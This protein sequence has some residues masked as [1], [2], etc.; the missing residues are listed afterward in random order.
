MPLLLAALLALHDSSERIRVQGWTEIP[1][2][3]TDGYASALLGR[4]SGR[5]LIVPHISKNGG[6]ALNV[7]LSS[8]RPKLSLAGVGT[9]VDCRNKIQCTSLNH[10]GANRFSLSRQ[11]DVIVV[12]K[13]GS[14]NLTRVMESAASFAQLA[15]LVVIRDPVE[16]VLSEFLF[17]RARASSAFVKLPRA[18][19]APNVTWQEWVRHPSE[20]NFQLAF[21]RGFGMF[22]HVTTRSD[23]LSWLDCMARTPV[24]LVTM[25]AINSVVPGM[26]ARMLPGHV[27]TQTAPSG[28]WGQGFGQRGANT[29]ALSCRSILEA[30]K[31]FPL[32]I[33]HCLS[34]IGSS[35]TSF[36]PW[37]AEERAIPLPNEAEREEVRRLN[38]FDEQLYQLARRHTAVY[39]RLLGSSSP[40]TA[41]PA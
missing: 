9:P 8:I 3:L 21:L 41:Q 36:A 14:D 10:N 38:S 7:M 33:A 18:L 28:R 13:D 22:T 16:R 40:G 2:P 24:A 32:A 11:A 25:D 26:L 20:S 31:Y 39:N 4:V 1:S 29:T 12:H 5:K 27:V 35:L 37:A 15:L 30:G 6:T 23:W 34:A 17:M 19:S